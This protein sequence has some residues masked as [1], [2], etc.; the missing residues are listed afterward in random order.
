MIWRNLT[1]FVLKYLGSFGIGLSNRCSIFGPVADEELGRSILPRARSTL[2]VATVTISPTRA[3]TSHVRHGPAVSATPTLR[4][5]SYPLY[6][7]MHNPDFVFFH[8]PVFLYV[9]AKLNINK[10]CKLQSLSYARQEL[11]RKRPFYTVPDG[12]TL[13]HSPPG[14]VFLQCAAVSSV[15]QRIRILSFFCCG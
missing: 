11:Y 4:V 3:G 9:I 10:H 12:T 5:E 2:A 15:A 6:N 14:M 7:N 1:S 13:S 8:C